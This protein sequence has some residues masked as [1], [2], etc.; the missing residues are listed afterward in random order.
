MKLY[1]DIYDR[2]K[3]VGV[4]I[5]YPAQQQDLFSNWD[6]VHSSAGREYLDEAQYA[7]MA[8]WCQLTFNTKVHPRR[9]RRMAYADFW[10]AS[11]R[12]LDWFILNWASVDSKDV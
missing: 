3:Y 6:D 5:W 2:G 9:A 8:S 1:F 7:R 12:D 4:N 10:F 11:K